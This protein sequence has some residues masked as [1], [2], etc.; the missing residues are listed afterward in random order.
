MTPKP[1]SLR[2][3]PHYWG[4]M[5][6][7][8]ALTLG[9]CAA[10]AP[11]VRDTPVIAVPSHWSTA[12][13]SASRSGSADLAQWWQRFN[14][15][16]LSTLVTQGLLANT[17][18]REAQAALRQARAL[19]DVQAAGLMPSLYG[20]GSARRDK[21]GSTDAGNSW[22]AGLDARWTPDVFG[23]QRSSLNASEAEAQASEASLADVQVSIAAEVALAYIQLRGLQ[24]Q[25][26][27]A[28][29]NL[30]SQQETLQITDW[31]AQAGLTTSLEVEQARTAT[32]QTSAQLPA[33]QAS[34]VKTR[35]SL[36]VLIG[37]TPDALQ[38]VLES[39]KAIPQI[40]D[41]WALRIPAEALR[42]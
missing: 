34:I 11:S 17:R 21:S 14:D 27:I 16:Q 36:A 35:H 13:D 3:R 23:G 10:L 22:R 38:T 33:L 20:S 39:P 31:R 1:I 4:G 37:Q 12:S 15:P 5:G 9:G 18:V 29:T 26:L 2:P 41:D 8:L 28:Q 24:T 25:W 40:A 30:A 19:R 7:T 6:L 42:Q 32:E